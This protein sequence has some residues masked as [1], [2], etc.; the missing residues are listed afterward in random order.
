[1]ATLST[2]TL[3][4]TA[5]NDDEHHIVSATGSYRITKANYLKELNSLVAINSQGIA[6]LDGVVEAIALLDSRQQELIVFVNEM[7]DFVGFVQQTPKAVVLD[8]VVL[9]DG[10]YVLTFCPS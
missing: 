6:D 10:D 4:T 8:S 7:A 2:R 3:L 1:M 9:T 5:N